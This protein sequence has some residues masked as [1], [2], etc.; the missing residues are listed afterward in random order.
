MCLWRLFENQNRIM[1]LP[2]AIFLAL[3][4]LLP[5]L[6]WPTS[7]VG[8]A[9][10]LY[11]PLLCITIWSALYLGAIQR[12]TI[13]FFVKSTLV[14]TGLFAAFLIYVLCYRAVCL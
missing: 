2:G 12:S 13:T 14:L 7:R 1:A 6:W 9:F 5:L 11:L 10:L 3:G 8:L 4:F